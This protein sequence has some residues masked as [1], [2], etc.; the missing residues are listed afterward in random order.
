MGALITFI[1]IFGLFNL[2]C[3]GETSRL[4]VAKE[5]LKQL[6]LQTQIKLTEVSSTYFSSTYFAQRPPN[7]RLINY[8]LNLLSANRMRSACEQ[9]A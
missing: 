7:E 9:R 5:L 6:N 3:G 4:E 8:K 1:E 2:V